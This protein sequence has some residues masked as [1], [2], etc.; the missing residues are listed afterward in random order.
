ME[1][2]EYC[3]DVF[4]LGECFCKPGVVENIAEVDIGGGKLEFDVRC[5]G[6]FEL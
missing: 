4:E 6:V 5:E 3:E 2:D 1:F